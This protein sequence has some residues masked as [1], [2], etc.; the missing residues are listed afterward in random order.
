MRRETS[1]SAS[2]AP[3]SAAG[4][5]GAGQAASG[6]QSLDMHR[7]MRLPFPPT[8]SPPGFCLCRLTTACPAD[9]IDCCR[10][11]CVPLLVC[12]VDPARPPA[13]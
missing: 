7:R 6:L 4:R 13:D 2:G 5:T 10:A 12:V 8:D 1:L 3:L 9:R 11:F